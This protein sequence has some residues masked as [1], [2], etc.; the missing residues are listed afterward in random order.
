MEH[1]YTPLTSDQL[2]VQQNTYLRQQE[3]FLRDMEQRPVQPM[4]S[5]GRIQPR[6]QRREQDLEVSVAKS[7]F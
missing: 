5:S 2:E 1:P 7:E 6:S 3:D 4:R